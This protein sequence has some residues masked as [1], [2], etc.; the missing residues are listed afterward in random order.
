[1]RTVIHHC[2]RCSIAAFLGT[3]LAC[4]TGSGGN[5]ATS[6]SDGGAAKASGEGGSGGTDSGGVGDAG[7]GGDG[8]DGGAQ[9]DGDA[10]G[11]WTGIQVSGTTFVDSTGAEFIPRGLAPGEWHNIES[12]MI[13]MSIN[14]S[15]GM[16]ET[17][18]TNALV[19][20]M[21]QT[22]T[23]QFFSTWEANVVTADDVA[24]WASW[25]VNSVRLPMN[26]HALTSADGV[27]KS[28]GFAELDAF[29]GWCK[30]NHIY[31]ILD[32]HAAPGSQN[33]EE[34][35]DTPDGTAHLWS[36]PAKY[37]QWTIDLWQ[38]IAKRY[39]NEPAVMGYDI[40]DE[41]YDTEND[42]SFSGGTAKV[43]LPMYKDITTAIRAVDTHHVLFFEGA[44]WS[45]IDSSGSPN[46]FDGLS[47]AWDDQMAWSF[48]E[49]VDLNTNA[50][51]TQ[52]LLDKY[53]ALRTSTN[54][55]IWHGETGEHDYAWLKA[56]VAL[57]EANKI[58]WNLWT[59]KKA[60][61]KS[62]DYDPSGA[63][64][65]QAYSIDEPA[66][67]SSML[68]YL[69]GSGSAPSNASTIMLAFAANA[70]TTTC[71]YNSGWVQAT[72]K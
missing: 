49:Y 32:L 50:P 43:L 66:N 24:E 25:G 7:G 13:A 47:P 70:A 4:G 22:A 63:D 19:K 27:Y 16:G 61:D 72:F 45:T 62:H 68:S 57:D 14:D 71:Q 33:C 28:A 26:Y 18:L 55:P 17:R 1:M 39:A 51:L 6:T 56:T 10:S 42:G 3:A 2:A 60:N 40:F 38:T 46:G 34:M 35:S 58:G 37:R 69:D 9:Q 21:G 52:S 11:T 23:D 64:P 31:V 48:H 12:Y 36:E 41:P 54:R 67:Y 53:I 29:I 8:G 5:G 20:A 15:P 30:A 59:Y 44:Y 65:T